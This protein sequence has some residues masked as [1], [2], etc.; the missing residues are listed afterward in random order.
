MFKSTSFNAGAFFS[1]LPPNWGTKKL[2]AKYLRYLI[3]SCLLLPV[4][5]RKWSV[6]YQSW[7]SPL[8]SYRFAMAPMLHDEGGLTKI[9]FRQ[10]LIFNF[11]VHILKYNIFDK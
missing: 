10:K 7:E 1:P 6:I 3:Q 8:V 5:I 2:K 4:E 9:N 11:D